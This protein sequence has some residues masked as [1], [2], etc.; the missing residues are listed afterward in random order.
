MACAGKKRILLKSR[1]KEKIKILKKLKINELIIFVRQYPLLDSVCRV[2]LF[3]YSCG[4]F[5]SFACPSVFLLTI[6]VSCCQLAFVQQRGLRQSRK[7]KGSSHQVTSV[8]ALQFSSSVGK[9][10]KA[11]Y[12]WLGHS[13]RS[14][15]PGTNYRSLQHMSMLVMWRPTGYAVGP[16]NIFSQKMWFLKIFFTKVR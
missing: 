11:I 6:C 9:T 8:M 13:V 1:K 5:S 14:S 3:S 2:F 7:E 15:A 10:D 16:Q 4:W 12:S